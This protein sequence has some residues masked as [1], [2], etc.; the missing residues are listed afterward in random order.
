MKLFFKRVFRP[1]KPDSGFIIAWKLLILCM[2]VV[3]CVLSTYILSFLPD[4]ELDYST[5]MVLMDLIFD[6]IYLFDILLNFRTAFYHRGELCLDSSKIATNYLHSFFLFDVISLVSIFGRTTVDHSYKAFILFDLLRIV[7][8]PR[9]TAKMQDYFQFSRQI[10][11]IFHLFKLCCAIIVFA[12]WWACC[13][14]SIAKDDPAPNSWILEAGLDPSN[15]SEVYVASMYWSIATMATIGYG[16]IHPVTYRERIL[17]IVIM[18]ASS[19]I[20][21]YILSSIGSVMSEIGAFNSE[22]RYILI[23]SEVLIW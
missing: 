2:I 18:I 16:D 21:G 6:I 3:Q 22:S 11:S 10:S 23:I 9:I 14:F 15:I 13:L 8:I 7:H 17:S 4:E 19:I 12:H 20:F 1:L 5:P